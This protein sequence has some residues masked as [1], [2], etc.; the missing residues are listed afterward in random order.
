HPLDHSFG[1]RDPQRRIR[2]GVLCNL[3]AAETGAYATLP[4]FE[5]L[6]RTRF[7][8]ILYYARPAGTAAEEY[9]RRRADRAAQ[10]PEKLSE[11]VAA[12]RAEDL[13][14]LHFVPNVAP[15]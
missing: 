12:L 10:V 4:L 9:C 14:L 1:P 3:M 2:L 7:E 13:D 6:D 5:H 11:L 8:V 15:T